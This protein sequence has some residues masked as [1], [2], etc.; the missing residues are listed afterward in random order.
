MDDRTGDLR[1]MQNAFTACLRDPS[2]P[3]PAGLDPARVGIYQHLVISKLT[4]LLENAF[5]VCAAMAGPGRWARLSADYLRCH[6]SQTPLF[7]ELAAEFLLWLRSLAELP[8]P[9]LA[10]LAHYEWVETALFQLDA[11]PPPPLRGDPFAQPLQR[12]RLAQVLVY[13]WPVH[14]LGPGYAPECPPEVPTALLVRREAQGG[15]RFSVLG[16][17][18]AQL[19]LLME[20]EPGHTG[21]GYLD[22]LA[23]Q[24]RVDTRDL[25]TAFR[26]LLRELG[27]QGVIGQA[28]AA[29]H[30]PGDY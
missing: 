19:L 5:P 16:P 23:L 1:Q 27:D 8:H 28:D 4:G 26:A 6:R 7:T 3:P 18:A 9:A 25:L 21:A 24:H 20:A 29:P 17:L 30:C 13:T 11:L 22:R 14:L 2:L 10:E 12:S 15:L